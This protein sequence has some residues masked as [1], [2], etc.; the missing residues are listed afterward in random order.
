MCGVG[1]KLLSRIKSIYGVRVNEGED[2]CFRIDSDVSRK[3]YN[4]V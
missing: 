1:G 4:G 2:E 3:L